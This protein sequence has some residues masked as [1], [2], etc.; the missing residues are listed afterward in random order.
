[1]L[2]LREAIMM[3]RVMVILLTSFLIPCMYA[4]SGS[5]S[6]DR[7][8]SIRVRVTLGD[9]RSCNIRATV[10]LVSTAGAHIAE[11]LT[12]SDCEV[13]FVNVASGSYR[14]SVSGAGIENS[15]SGRFNLDSRA[16]QDL[17][18]NIPHTREAQHGTTGLAGPLVAAVDLNI[19]EG[20]R[21][22][23]DKA[24]QF[25]A[26]GNWHKAIERLN[27]AITIYPSYAEA[28]NNLGVVYGR[29]G[30]RARNLEALQKAVSLNDHFAPAYL[31]LARM[32][33]AD[34]D[35]VQTEVLLDKAV[36]IEPT[37]SQMLVLLANTELLNHHYDQALTNC[38]KAHSSAQGPHAVAHYVAARVFEY[39]NR[40]TDAVAELQIFL[41]EEQRGPRADIARKEMNTLQ[42]KQ[43]SV[44]TQTAR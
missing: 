44:A 23:F 16:R 34:G 40:P 32:A 20:A 37:N 9:A 11:D 31:N 29:L 39:E 3:R 15:D 10:S 33:I 36:A 42:Q 26:K 7:T 4:Q 18:I 38:R 25:V 21:K 19:P 35:L 22:E 24:N 14:V 28:Y 8:G 27:K 5:G 13:Y 30:D 6:Q 41:S 12:N 43:S 17:E 2:T 1:M